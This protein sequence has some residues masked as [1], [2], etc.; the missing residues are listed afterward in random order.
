MNLEAYTQ[1]GS[2]EQIAKDNG[3]DI[4]RLRGY[5]LMK[6]A[7]P[8]TEEAIKHALK[9]CEVD[10]VE[11][12]CCSDPFWDP[13]SCCSEFS[14]WTDLLKDYYLI[15]SE[16]PNEYGQYHYAGIRWDRIHGWK[17]RI[18]KFEI[19]KQKRRII[20][21]YEMHNKY[22]GR[23]DVLYIHSRMG[24]NN[25]KYWDH[26]K[27]TELMNQP[28]FLDRVDDNWDSTYCDFYA[29]IK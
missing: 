5:M 26:D 9:S 11:D 13:N 23:E 4:P 1:I 16:E 18:L 3:I 14:G 15:K 7:E 8:F 28:W 29:K 2:L 22:A 27:K 10:V 21:Q 25:W 17:R 19:K 20:Q 6:D 12:L 24:G